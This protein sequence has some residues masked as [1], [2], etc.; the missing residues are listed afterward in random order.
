MILCFDLDNVVCAT[1]NIKYKKAKPIFKTIKLI[2]KAYALGFKIIIFTGRY[3]GTC[4][5]NL[6]KIIKMDNGIT[7]K[8]LKKWGVR[9]HSLL[10][11][12]PAFDVYVDDKNFEFKK[13][14][15]NKFS[16]HL[17]KIFKN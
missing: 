2:N 12:K 13:N 14:W 17:L 15:H 16:K 9:Y 1:K 3:Y 6:K 8:Q 11:G 5:G 4:G 10:F 7:K